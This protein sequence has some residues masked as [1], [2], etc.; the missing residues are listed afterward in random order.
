MPGFN[1]TLL[2]AGPVL[3]LVTPT[4]VSVWVATSQSCSVRLDV[5]GA[6]A[7]LNR[8]AAAQTGTV[9]ATVA[10]TGSR[11]TVRVGGALHVAVVTAPIAGVPPDTVC[12][13]NVTLDVQGE[14]VGETSWTGQWD[15]GGLKLLDLGDPADDYQG[16]LGYAAGRLPS[17]VTA[18]ADVAQLRL[19]HGSCFKLHGDGPSIMP[20]IDDLLSDALPADATAT[21]TRP[22]LLLL[23][24]DQI[25]E[26]G[27][28]HV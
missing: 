16:G 3:R 5:Y 14:S 12:S 2:L 21:K 26:I 19:F 23:T 25:Y 22:H 9:S 24:G 17:F 20:N 11:G 6:S 28:A 8:P 4:S 18:P 13:Y 27:R 15:L 10:G 1:P 7:F